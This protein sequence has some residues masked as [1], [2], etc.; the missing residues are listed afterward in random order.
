[1]FSH[2]FRAIFHLIHMIFYL[3]IQIYDEY[4]LITLHI[5]LKEL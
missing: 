4:I 5:S 2:L 3:D 1:M